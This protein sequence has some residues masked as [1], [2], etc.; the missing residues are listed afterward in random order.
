MK[1]AI[2][3]T[4]GSF[5]ERWIAYCNEK[6]IEYKCV[7][8]YESDI[9]LQLSDCDCLMWHF[10]HKDSKDSKF[11]KQLL[12]AV[13]ASGKKVF[14]DFNSAWHFDDKVAQ[15]YF[16]EAIGSPLAKSY[17][18][19]TKMEALQWAKHTIYPKVFKLRNGAGSD[20]VKLVKN[21]SDA[22]RWIKKAFGKGFKQY[23][24]WNN[25]KERYRKYKLRKTNLWDVIKGTL[26][27]VYT[28]KYSRV[29]G[30]EMGY[31]YFQDFIPDNDHDIR[32][33]VVGDKAFGI[34]RMVRE[35]DFR[36]SGSGTIMYDKD[37]FDILT[38]RLA[39]ETS[40]RLNSQCMAYDFIYKNGNPLIVEISYGFAMKGY[41]AC[42]GYFDKDLIW[43]EGRFNPYGWMVEDLIT[44][45]SSPKDEVKPN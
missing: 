38:V 24:A 28:T 45:V 26:R 10:N 11:A 42:P 3:H 21:R 8:C 5:S 17:V 44:S 37:N 13:Q 35:N 16:L 25:L 2:H 27:L 15:K 33:I 40:R 43:Y 9:I 23:E 20:N 7:N 22:V 36:A 34:K 32:V 18:F 6:H 29:T 31:V 12:F 41:D 30:R 1:I 39:I 19:Y 4:P 14:P